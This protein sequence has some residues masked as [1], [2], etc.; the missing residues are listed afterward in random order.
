MDMYTPGNRLAKQSELSA[1][2]STTFTFTSVA[3]DTPAAWVT[4]A[5]MDRFL[6]GDTLYDTPRVADGN[7]INGGLGPVY[8]GYA[9]GSC[10]V[11]AGRTK[12]HL[13][14]EG[15]SGPYGFSAFLTFMR[16]PN[17]QYH[18]NYGR[19]LH[20]QAIYG[21]SPE[22]KLK[23]SYSEVFY[24]FSDGEPYSL[25]TPTYTITDWYANEI[26]DEN[27]E[28]SVRTPLRHVGLGLMMAL[29][30]NEILALAGIEY[31]EYGISGEVNWVIER[32]H[33]Q[34]GLSGHKAQHAD[35]TV[36]LGF[37]S[38]MGVT[39][40]RFPHEI[41]EGQS[42]VD[43]DYGI[44]ISTKDMGDVDFYLHS[45]GVPARRYV[46]NPVVKQG[47]ELFYQ[48]KCNLCHTPTLHTKPGGVKLI[49]GTNMPWLGNQTI[50]PYSDFLLHDM[51]P[52]LGDDFSQFNASGDEWRTT[53]LWGIG[54]QNVVNGHTTFLHDSRARNFVEAIMWHGGE[55]DVSR[56][57]FKQMQ[58]NDRDALITFLKSL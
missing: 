35:L 44:Q 6:S 27:L 41:S 37:L 57:L 2:N 7:P 20:D 23:V 13:L 16:T 11:G 34:M 54:L 25:I 30:Q 46:D 49:D 53:P 12:S 52:E 1:G 48:A 58:K 43:G 33:K 56:Q 39:S 18:R 31:P 29:D 38:D 5:L 9:C 8:S 32:N 22:G 51:G 15:G 10:H 47:E 21:V 45:L 40:D 4:G 26:P 42:Q 19:V 14:T 28:M 55:G 3:F 24:T 50:H 17:N 36:E